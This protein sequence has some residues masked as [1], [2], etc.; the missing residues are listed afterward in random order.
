MRKIFLLTL[1]LASPWLMYAQFTASGTVQAS[2]NAEKLIGVTVLEKGTSNGTSTDFDG[3]FTL[4]V[5]NAEAV[6]VISYVGFISQEIKAASG[7]AVQLEEDSDLLD[8]VVVIG[9][10]TQKK[11]VVTGAISTIKAE[12]LESMPVIRLE[13]SLQGRVSG[14]RVTSNSGQPGA[15][16][17]VRIRGTS[18]INN[19]E[20][21]YVVDGVP[22]SG[23]IEYLNQSDIQSIEVLKDAASASI[24]GARSAS[25]VILVTTKQGKK[26]RFEINYHTYFGYQ[27]PW[28]K[29]PLLN[30]REYTTLMN[31]SS[32]AAGG[33]ILFPDPSSYTTST[34]WQDAVFNYKAPMQNH[35]M[36]LAAGGEKSQ[37]FLSFGY[38]KQAGIV[39]SAQSEFER[40]ST[41]LNSTHKISKYVSLG[42]NVAYTHINGLGVPENTEFGSPLGRAINLDPLTPVVVTDTAISN[43]PQYTNFNVVR[44]ENGNPY[45]ISPYV[46]SEILNPVAAVQVQPNRGWS[47]KIVAS[48]YLEVEPIKGLKFNSNIGTDVAFWGNESFSPIYYLNASNRNDLTRYGRSQNKGLHW[49]W[50][51]TVSYNK[52]IDLHAIS[53]VA[54]VVAERNFGEGIGGQVQ[55]I[56]VTNIDDA[57]LLFPTS[58]DNQ[59]F[60]G[61]EYNSTL[62]SYLGR[63]NYNFNEKYLFSATLRVDG[64]SKF[65]QNNKFGFF[66]A[67]SA[68]WVLTEEAFLR[69]NPSINFLKLRASWGVNGNDQIGDFRYVSTVGG[70]RNYTFGLND[71]LVSGYSPNAIANPDLKWEQ[72]TQTN[73]GFDARLFKDITLTFDW[74]MKNTSGMLLQVAVPGYVG[75][76]GPIGN[77]ATMSNTGFEV[78]LGYNKALKSGWE[79]GVSGNISYVKNEVT[80]IGPDKEF[81]TGQRF[82][83]QSLEITRTQ[84]GLPVGYFFGYQTDGIFQNQAEVDAYT[85]ADGSPIQPDASPG[86]FRFKDLDGDGTIDADDRTMIGDPTPNWTYGFNLSAAYKGFDILLFGQ[87]VWGND[88]YNATRRFDLQ[89]ANLTGD[90]LNRWTGEGSTNDYPRL[91]MNDPN[92][93]FSRSSDFYV[94]NGAFFRVKTLQ[95]GYTVPTA[96]SER[97]KIKRL[98]LYVSGNNILTLTAYKGFDPE[99]GGGSFGVDRGNYPQARSILFG[100]NLTL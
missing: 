32:V 66:P 1:L 4:E 13:N 6:L 92:Q 5:A 35:E 55:G 19:S 62:L 27:S 47:D 85:N 76:A 87:G 67:V 59:S 38:F 89:M 7:L 77:I 11:S 53:L 21:L 43:L 46:T 100:L 31:E 60:Y 10:G 99:I 93:N 28:K 26:D 58:I 95:L 44:D 86:D 70:G 24:Y 8:E 84:V 49:I 36:S 9:Y 41:R 68:G 16:A 25:G 52:L 90:A 80:D 78:E 57:S 98:R 20:P 96:L 83:P 72:T 37:Y 64:S 88:V 29:L 48:A 12:D 14:V 97:L 3:N 61:F 51:N 74:F 71:D 2:K 50:Q 56:P 94:Q 15:A 22:I 73:F 30:A 17:T 45:G 40:I 42:T 79:F 39:S 75:N 54:G 34:D 63:A 33:N 65:G 69:K 18:S 91:V 81:L 23:G 82:S